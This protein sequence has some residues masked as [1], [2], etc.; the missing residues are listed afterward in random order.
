M[1]VLCVGIYVC[2]VS[3]CVC[4]VC[5]CRMCVLWG[6]ACM[7]VKWCVCSVCAVHVVWVYLLYVCCVGVC[8]YVM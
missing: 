6:Y 7:Y 5:M 1:C 2:D 8:M 3:V 4:A